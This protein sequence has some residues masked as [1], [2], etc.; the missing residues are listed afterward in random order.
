MCLHKENN[1]LGFMTLYFSLEMLFKYANRFNE[2][3]NYYFLI[4]HLDF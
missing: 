2:F 3:A 4:V 1:N